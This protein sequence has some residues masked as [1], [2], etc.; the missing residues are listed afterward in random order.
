[1]KAP[2]SRS[3]RVLESANEISVDVLC[4]G[5]WARVYR[6]KSRST[7]ISYAAKYSSR[8]RFN[9]DCSAEL[10]HEIALLSLCSQSPRVV[11]LHDV[12]ETSK[13]IILV[14]E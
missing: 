11:R 6:C 2:L 13:E 10:R 14:M 12:Y 5:Q 4:S 7:G 9:A 3:P 8:N 1:M